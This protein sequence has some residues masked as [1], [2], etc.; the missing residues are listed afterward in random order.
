MASQRE[1]SQGCHPA[2]VPLADGGLEHRSA[3]S[4]Q[5]LK[6]EVLHADETKAGP[7]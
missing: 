4:E 3:Q 2:A 7:S 1:R 5:L 6:H